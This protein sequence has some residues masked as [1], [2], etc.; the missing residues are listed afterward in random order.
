RLRNQR[1]LLPSRLLMMPLTHDAAILESD[2]GGGG[3]GAN[4]PLQVLAEAIYQPKEVQHARVVVVANPFMRQSRLGREPLDGHQI[5]D[6]PVRFGTHQP[7]RAPF[8]GA[9]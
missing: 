6:R 1:I 3:A 7:S 2:A 4:E 5:V 8:L 9:P